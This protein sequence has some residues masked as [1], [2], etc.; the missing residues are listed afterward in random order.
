[1][2]AERLKTIA[3]ELRRLLRTASPSPELLATTTRTLDGIRRSL[4]DR[5]FPSDHAP[6]LVVWFIR[7]AAEIAPLLDDSDA[8][9]MAALLSQWRDAAPG[10]AVI[11]LGI[12]RGEHARAAC[13]LTSFT[14][15]PASEV[16]A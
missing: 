2:D 13:E 15:E 16:A 10:A 9:D 6:S 1:M 4:S 12:V 14:T 11:P 8:R 3:R 5:R 7:N